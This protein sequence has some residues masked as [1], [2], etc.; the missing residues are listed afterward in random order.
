MKKTKILGILLS[1]LL[2][3]SF[4]AC[5][6]TDNAPQGASSTGS[7]DGVLKSYASGT[8]VVTRGDNSELAFD[9][10]KATVS[11]KNM[12]SG[13][14]LTILYDGTIEGTDTSG[15]TVTEIK[16]NGSAAPKEQTMVGTV[17]NL[18]QHSLTLK[19]PDGTEYSFN[20]AGVR[21]A[22]KNGIENGNWVQVKYVGEINGT[23]ATGVKVLE[24]VDND[25]NIKKA[26][27]PAKVEIKAADEKVWATDTVHVRE[28]YTTDSNVLGDLAPGNEITRTG[29]CDNGWSRVNYNGKDAFV[30]SQY[31][32]TTQPASPSAPAPAKPQPSPSQPAQPSAQPT[33]K[34]TPAPTPA[35][36]PDPTPAPTP[37]PT[38]APT[39]EPTPEPTPAPAPDPTPEPTPEPEVKTLTGYVVSYADGELVVF[40]NG[41]DYPLNVTDAQHSYVSGIL[42]GNEVTV[43]YTGDLQA[44]ESVVVLS[45][46]DSELNAGDRSV[47]TGV[48]ASASMNTLDLTTDDNTEIMFETMNAEVNSQNYQV[49]ARVSVTLDLS[50]SVDTSNIFHALKVDDAQ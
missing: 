40:A 10:S 30:Y 14:K 9:L 22:Y 1:V 44:Y 23:D 42:T 35:P 39:P 8:L 25:E 12:L 24:I 32:T 13:D 38:T 27:E 11:C 28:S 6:K 4:A 47:I 18:T 46:S 34:P 21:Q 29:V 49:G 31:L 37:E 48:I 5:A 2:A 20:T 19:E 15:V 3:V 7:V 16:D 50:Q 45:V 36:A 33:P 26:Q 17:R 43:T 41:A